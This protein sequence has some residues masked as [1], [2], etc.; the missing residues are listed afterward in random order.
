[1]ALQLAARWS[2]EVTGGGD[3]AMGGGWRERGNDA[4][5]RVQGLGQRVVEPAE[6]L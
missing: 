1:M 6:N 3:G 2:R 4:G 5:L